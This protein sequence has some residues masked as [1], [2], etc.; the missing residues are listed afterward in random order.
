MLTHKGFTRP[1]VMETEGYE[2]RM[3]GNEIEKILD[4]NNL[5]IEHRYF[6]LSRPDSLQWEYLNT[7]QESADLHYINQLFRKI[8][9]GKW[10][11]TGIS[12]GGQTAIFYKFY[13]P[14]D[15]DASVPYVAPLTN[16][17]EDK[18]I[19]Q[20]LDTM[21]SGECRATIFA[22]QKFLLMHEPEILEKL[23]W[24]EKGTGQTYK[25]FDGL[26]K[27]FEYGVLEYPFSFW[28]TGYTPCEKIPTNNSVDDYLDHFIEITGIDWMSDKE[29]ARWA[30]HN[31]MARAETGYYG[32]DITRFKKW[33]H[34]IS[35]ENP[36]AA[37]APNYLSYSA[38]DT[39][40][41]HNVLVWLDEKG[42]NFVYINGGRDTWSACRVIVSD[43]VNSKSFLVPGAN[44]YEARVR[45]MPDDQKKE[46][47]AALSGILHL[48]VN[49]DA[50]GN[51]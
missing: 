3:S 7:E 33:L 19:F 17:L 40:F 11:S 48:D 36:S 42:N 16:S 10:I 26:G 15:V 29:L 6:G 27:V 37:L 43:K 1:T 38:F 51:K 25:Y 23:K 18:R 28:Q 22:F 45:N 24:Y 30:A 47:A 39:T 9:P 50:L 41:D 49:L 31:Y 44:H 4:A 2:W 5:N 32:Y 46:F 35:G 13:Y 20:F 34:Y 21:G 14:D 12:R 8:Y